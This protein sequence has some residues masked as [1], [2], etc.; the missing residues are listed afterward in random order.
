MLS[1]KD[2]KLFEKRHASEVWK[3]PPKNVEVSNFAFERVHP[4]LITA[5]ISDLGVLAPANF[6][7][8]FDKKW[9][10]L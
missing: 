5:I 8:A 3:T 7:V 9:P 10:K 6:M 4:N 2:S 1:T